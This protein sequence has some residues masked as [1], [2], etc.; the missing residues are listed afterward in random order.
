MVIGSGFYYRYSIVFPHRR[1]I[2][3]LHWCCYADSVLSNKGR[4]LTSAQRTL[5]VSSLARTPSPLFLKLMLDRAT[6]WRPYTPVDGVVVATSV[7]NGITQLFSGLE[8]KFGVMFVSRTLGYITV[9]LNGL[10]EVRK[11]IILCIDLQCM[12]S[13]NE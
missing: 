3:S 5:L 4:T 2:L 8:R 9:G 10:S 11:N 7:R 6:S 13:S 12:P 1:Y